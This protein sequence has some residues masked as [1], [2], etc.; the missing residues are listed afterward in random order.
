MT[1]KY[2]LTASTR[3]GR[4]APGG[5]RVQR[6][7]VGRRYP[8]ALCTLDGSAQRTPPRMVGTPSAFSVSAMA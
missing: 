7:V 3:S 1:P 2:F 8:T 6:D 5:G 4:G